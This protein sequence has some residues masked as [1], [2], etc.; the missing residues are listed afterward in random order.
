MV[1]AS[2][3]EQH[4]GTA[5]AG[6]RPQVFVLF[7]RLHRARLTQQQLAEPGAADDMCRLDLDSPTK[8]G[9]GPAGERP[10]PFAN[11]MARSGVERE[12]KLRDVPGLR[13]NRIVP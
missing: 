9:F 5:S 2:Q 11:E 7:E 1:A 6:S 10:V 4:R 12:G 13:Q 8:V 3:T